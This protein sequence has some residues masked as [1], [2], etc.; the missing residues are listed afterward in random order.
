MRR[1][2]LSALLAL[3]LL[4]GG[5][6]WSNRRPAQAASGREP[7]IVIPGMAGS[8]LSAGA[9]FHLGVDNGH[10]GVYSRDY[11]SGEKVWVN[12]LQAALPGDDDYFDALK[13]YPDGRTAVAP[14]LR[15]SDIYHPGYDDLVA[16][17]GRQGTS[18]A[19]ISGSSPMTGRALLH[20]RRRARRA[21]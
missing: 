2:R 9:A 11:A 8:E 17:L 15:V 20:L 1:T 14:E 5:A 7:V 21:H 6:A 4:V 16:Y 12:I 10:G 18:R 19:S 13:L 3:V